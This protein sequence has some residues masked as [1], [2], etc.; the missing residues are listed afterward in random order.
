MRRRELADFLRTRRAAL[1][2]RDVGL[3]EGGRRRTPGLRREEVAALA[4]VGTTW[5]TWL[6]Q[7]R[8][9]RA[10]RSV[11]EAVGEAL[12]LT[13]AE[14]R[15]L[16]RLGRGEELALPGPQREVVSGTLDRLIA[17][18]GAN[19]AYVLGRRWDYLAWNDATAALFGD[20]AARPPERRNHVWALFTDPERQALVT[21]WD[22]TTRAVVARFRG[23][24]AR[25]VGDPAFE[26]LIADLKAVS[27]EFRRLWKRHEIVG[28]LVGRKV[29]RHPDVGLL[30]FEH[31]ALRP[32]EAPEQRLILYSPL[33][34]HDTASKMMRLMAAWR[35]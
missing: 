1:T 4:G 6:E 23:D 21:D 27:P 29:L 32:A 26:E 13:P 33:P 2:P 14:H 10:S 12:R 7:A 34:E 17:N 31:A 20:P 25:H 16:V 28:D 19:P 15:H 35:G 22:D 11:L 24:A 3:P 8:D 5:Y 30:A 18:L 9:V